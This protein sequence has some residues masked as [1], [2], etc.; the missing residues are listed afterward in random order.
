M[1][2]IVVKAGRM[3]SDSRLTVSSEEGGDRIFTVRKIFRMKNGLVVGASGENGPG[4]VFIRWAEDLGKDGLPNRGTP[5]R[6][7]L[8]DGASADDFQA[9][10]LTESGDLVSYDK[11]FVPEPIDL[12]LN[13]GFYAIGSGAKAALGAM[14][15]DPTISAHQAVIIAALV[16][17]W[18]AGP[19]VSM[20]PGIPQELI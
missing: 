18:T 12:D 19:Y 8:M 5:E 4:L 20:S 7:E 14:H 16:D 9:L 6:P 2:T 11:F 3:A 15:A 13:H 1:T 10:V 17:P